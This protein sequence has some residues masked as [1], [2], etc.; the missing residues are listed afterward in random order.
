MPQHRFLWGITTAAH[1]VEGGL[2]TT[3]GLSSP[4]PLSLRRSRSSAAW[5]RAIWTCSSNQP[6]SRSPRLHAGPVPGQTAGHQCVWFL[7]RVESSSAH[8]RGDRPDGLDRVL[9]TRRTSTGSPGD[10]APHHT[11]SHEPARLGSDSTHHQQADPVLLRPIGGLEGRP[12]FSGIAVWLGESRH[13]RKF[14]DFVRLVVEMLKEEGVRYWLTF[15][16]PV[17]SIIVCWLHWISVPKMSVTQATSPAHPC[18]CIAF[19]AV[20]ILSTPLRERQRVRRRGEDGR[21]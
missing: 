12:G 3:I 13:L 15:D 9:R 7:G 14:L 17:A 11:Q 18:T 2:K 16:D 1:Q 21:R 19:I 6:R 4:P 5:D 8:S 20:A 10:R